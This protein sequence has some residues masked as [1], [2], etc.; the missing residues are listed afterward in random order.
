MRF[1]VALHLTVTKADTQREEANYR[2]YGAKYHIL[3]AAPLQNS[4]D[5]F[6]FYFKIY[7]LKILSNDITQ[8]LSGCFSGWTRTSEELRNKLTHKLTDILVE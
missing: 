6:K 2:K 7:V 1:D 3:V 5:F 4:S 8:S